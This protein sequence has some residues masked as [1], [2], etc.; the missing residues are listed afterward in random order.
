MNSVQ[1]LHFCN[2]ECSYGVATWAQNHYKNNPSYIFYFSCSYLRCSWLSSDKCRSYLAKW[3]QLWKD[4]EWQM[5]IY[6]AKWGWRL[7]KVGVAEG[8]NIEQVVVYIQLELCCASAQT[9]WRDRISHII[10]HMPDVL[11]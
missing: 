9:G 8:S 10:P 7:V 6:L 2:I 5:Q 4:E 11:K 3:V 1:N